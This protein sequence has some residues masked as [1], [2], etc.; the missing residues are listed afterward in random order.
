MW[1]NNHQNN[2]RG[3]PSPWINNGNNNNNSMYDNFSIGNLPFFSNN[4]NTNPPPPPPLVV[5]CGEL[6][7]VHEGKYVE[8]T[9]KFIKKRIGRFGELRDRNGATQLVISDDRNPRIS[10][11]F[12][13]MPSE[14]ILTIVGTVLTR[15]FGSRNVTMPTGE[16]EVE[17]ED[18]LN[19]ARVPGRR[20]AEKRSYSTMSDNKKSITSTEYKMAGKTENILKHFEN[21]EYTCNDLRKNHVGQNVTLVGWVSNTT[22][23]KFQHL[24]D[25]YGQTQI[26]IEEKELLDTFSSATPTCIVQVKGKVLAR[27]A[28]NINMKFETGDIEIKVESVKILNADEPYDG[29]VKEKV[30]KIPIGKVKD[31]DDGSTDT[32]APVSGIAD[33]NKFTIRTHNCGELSGANVAEK[34]NIAG[35]LEFQRMGKFLVLRDGYGQTQVLLSDKCNITEKYPDGIPLESIVRVEGTV[36]PRPSNMLNLAMKTGEIEIEATDIEV[37]NP[38]KKNLPFEVRGHQRANETLRMTHRYLDLRFSDMQKNLRLRSSILMKMREFLINYLGFVEVETPTL[39]RRTPGGAQEFV[40]P[41]RKPGHFYSLVQ[42]PQQFKQMLMAGAIDRYFQVARCYRDE[43]TRQDRQPEFT[44]LDIEMSFTTQKDVM[45]MI[46]ET[47]KFCW[48]KERG[49]IETPFEIISYDEAMSKY[50]CDQPDARFELLLNDITEIVKDSETIQNKFKDLGVCLIHVDKSISLLDA[51][52]RK[53]LEQIG[54]DFDGTFYFRKFNSRK[55]A[56][57]RLTKYLGADGAKNTVEK[58]NI[59]ADDL[60]FL[61]IGE[62]VNTR[63]LMGRLRLDYADL[64]EEN[65]LLPRRKK[66]NKFLWVVDFPM[67]FKTEDGGYES[68]HHPFTA[69][70]DEYLEQLKNKENLENIKSQAYDLV[71]NGNEVGGGSIRIHNK[72]L[73][74]FV[75]EEILKIPHEHLNHLLSALES[76]CPPHGGIALGIDRLMAFICQARSIRDVIAFPKSLNGR[77]PLSKAPV[78]ISDEEKKLYHLVIDGDVDKDEEPEQMEIEDVEKH[79]E[80]VKAD[81]KEEVIVSD[82][83]E[84]EVEESKK[85]VEK[86]QKVEPIKKTLRKGI[87]K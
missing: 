55:D 71:L 36:I 18:V 13:N 84:E 39:F 70:Q 85:I 7:P 48:P 2:N 12:Q 32:S 66:M 72:D 19:L 17:V 67:F 15:P 29:P 47:L 53:H 59:H 34:V 5:N 3:G 58:C 63:T 20:G 78:P 22:K 74:K 61:A 50:G 60:V 21:R 26:I 49:T 9:G 75:L 33:T 8:M 40:V 77:D 10:R 1:N 35:W 73:Q 14:C 51:P 83:N 45:S 54:N 11:R 16:I 30:Q 81:K 57:D 42:S 23:T 69:P 28:T 24:K 87:L 4:L 82:N 31:T 25:G 86:K 80:S 62:K 46:E 56:K 68:A 65:E 76:G 79:S 64:L 41:T 38:S 37:L 6:R 52:T 44:Q 43:A 27:P